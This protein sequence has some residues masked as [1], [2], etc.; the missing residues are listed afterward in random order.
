MIERGRE[1][2][3]KNGEKWRNDKKRCRA[4]TH[5]LKL[6]LFEM[7]GFFLFNTSLS[8][9]RRGEGSALSLA[10]EEEEAEEET[11]SEDEW[12]WRVE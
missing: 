3:E 5:R 12:A 11:G 10:G 6:A 9:W 7:E 4:V 1:E 2:N 8:L